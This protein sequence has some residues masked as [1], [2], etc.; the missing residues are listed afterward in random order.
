MLS[1]DASALLNRS[2][3]GGSV[4]LSAIQ[5]PVRDMLDSVAG[6]IRRIVVS[7]FEMIEDVNEHLL[8]MQGKLFRPT[9]LLLSDAVGGGEGE[10]AL[11]LAAVVE[12]VHLA[13]LVTASSL[14]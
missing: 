2:A 14:A 1:A 6:E 12:L 4:Q 10:D 8:F 11:T 13:T 9:L 7:D 3:R 5:A